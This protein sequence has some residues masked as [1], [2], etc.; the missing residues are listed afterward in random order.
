MKDRLFSRMGAPDS[1]KQGFYF[2]KVRDEED[3][4][5]ARANVRWACSPLTQRAR[6]LRLAMLGNASRRTLFF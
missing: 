3:G 5:G 1:W 6:W 2:S 4:T